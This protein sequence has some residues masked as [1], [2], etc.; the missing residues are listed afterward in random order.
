MLK[1]VGDTSTPDM[2][3]RDTS[4]PCFV[5][6]IIMTSCVGAVG[7]EDLDRASAS[8]RENRRGVYQAG[9]E[10]RLSIENSK[11]RSL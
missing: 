8:E 3:F 1:Q 7:I 10:F 9:I 11:M 6:S 2:G 4:S 5:R